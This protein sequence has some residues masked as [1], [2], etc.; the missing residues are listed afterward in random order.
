MRL[1]ALEVVEG[2]EARVA[3]IERLAGR[4]AEFA[5]AR[6]AL[7][8]AARAGDRGIAAPEASHAAE[9]FRGRCDAIFPELAAALRAQPIARPGRREH[10]DCHGVES[11]APERAHD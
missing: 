8:S 5:L 1:E 9:G 6:R 7:G 3:A 2:L 4:G 10:V 11:R